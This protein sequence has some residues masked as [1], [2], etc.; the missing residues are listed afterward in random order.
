MFMWICEKGNNYSVL[1]GM[2]LRITAVEISVVIPQKA[3][4]GAS[5]D[6]PVP[7]R[8]SPKNSVSYSRVICWIAVLLMVTRNGSSADV[9]QL[10]NDR[11]N[12]CMYTM[13]YYSG[14]CRE[15]SMMVLG[16]TTL[17]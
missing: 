8:G 2:K 7:Y 9:H 10:V 12:V 15:L 16:D 13:E 5:Y 4:N 14:N 3:R 6:P 1:V 11:E 17:T